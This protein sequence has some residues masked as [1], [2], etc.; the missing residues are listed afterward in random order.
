MSITTDVG[1]WTQRKCTVGFAPLHFKLA[2]GIWLGL[3]IYYECYT[4]LRALI[5][6]VGFAVER[7]S[8]IR[9]VL[10]DGRRLLN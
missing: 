2:D 4:E 7:S 1:F 5:D 8:K 10:E 9:Y 6:S 3:K